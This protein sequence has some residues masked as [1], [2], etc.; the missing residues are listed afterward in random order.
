MDVSGTIERHKSWVV[1]AAGTGPLVACAVLS[2]FRE[3]VSAATAVLVLVLLVVGAASTGVRLAGIVAA[4]SGGVWFDFFLTEP[5][6][7]LTIDDPNDVEATVLLVVIGA[8]VT[9]VA[10]WGYRHQAQAVRRAGYLDGVLGTAEIIT[11]RSEAPAALVEHV[12]D[13]IGQTLGVTRSRFVSGPVRDAR[14]AV[15]DHKGQVTRGS[16]S[17]NVDRD[18][19]P[20]DDEIALVV[21][22]ADVV[23]GHFL[24]TS[25]SHIARPTLE[26]RKVA[27]LLADQVGPVLED[28][29]SVGRSQTPTDRSSKKQDQR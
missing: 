21:T 8:A 29:A 19:L 23:L 6:L 18:G 27:V 11:L 3:S 24:L 12:A 17:V 25:A 26:Q 1:A 4:L 13:Q 10:L 15:L 20:T 7:R 16:H 9:E 22:R 28:Q 5:Y 14:I 2:V